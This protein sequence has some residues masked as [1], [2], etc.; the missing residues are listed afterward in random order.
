MKKVVLIVM[1]IMILS[2]VIS[3]KSEPSLQEYYVDKQES[4]DF[5][6]LDLPS[7]IITLSDDVTPEMKET[8]ASIKKLNVLAFKIDS[9][10]K[11]KYLVEFK[12]VKEILNNDNFNELV[13]MKHEN[14]NIIIKYLGTDEAVDEFIILAADNKKGFALARVLGDKMNPEKIM[15]LAQNINDVDKDNSAFA[16]I[17]GLIND[18]K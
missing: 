10:N 1:S 5:I 4:N 3:C 6:S 8:M 13:R 15:K 16:Q 17:E 11:D 12:K 14:A 18:F 7:S 2:S 9:L